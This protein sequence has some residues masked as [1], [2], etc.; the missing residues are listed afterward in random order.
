M[1]AHVYRPDIDGL[2]AVAVVVAVRVAR[3]V[4]VVMAVRLKRAEAVVV[5]HHFAGP[6][7]VGV[8]IAVALLARTVVV[9]EL[10][11]RLGRLE[12]LGWLERFG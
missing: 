1:P 2:R 6:V 11:R 9:A 5:A 7:A 4:A 10:N 3:A 8:A 12:R